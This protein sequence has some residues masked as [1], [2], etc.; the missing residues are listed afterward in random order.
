MFPR[1]PKLTFATDLQWRRRFARA[2]DDLAGDLAHGNWPQPTCTAEEL[3]LHLAID[4]AG[5]ST[6]ELDDTV[7]DPHSTLPVHRDDYDFG[8]CTDMF[9]Q[10][11]DVLM[12]YSSR[13]VGIE[14][15]DGDANR[16]LGVGDLRAQ[17]WFEPF[18]NITA[19][20]PHRGFRH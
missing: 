13:F 1:L 8:A 12:L 5:D 10:D 15:P 19:R 9:F 11:T 2:A 17:F 20:D 4:D 18:G 7:A 6:D 16:R 3:A 14:D